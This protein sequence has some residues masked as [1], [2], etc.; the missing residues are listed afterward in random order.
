M[1]RRVAEVKASKASKQADFAYDLIDLL[2]HL[3]MDLGLVRSG[4]AQ[5]ERGAWIEYH[6]RSQDRPSTTT[7]NRAWERWKERVKSFKLGITA[8]DPDAFRWLF[9][10]GIPAGQSG[11]TALVSR[12]S[13]LLGQLRTDERNYFLLAAGASVDWSEEAIDLGLEVSR[14]HQEMTGRRTNILKPP[15]KSACKVRDM[16]PTAWVVR[17]HHQFKVRMSES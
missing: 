14:K 9:A 8:S 1:S 3:D 15:I 6:Y 5:V 7:A 11:K 12:V 4:L 2:R 13:H 10:K 16:N 17:D